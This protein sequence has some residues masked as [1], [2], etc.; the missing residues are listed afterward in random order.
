MKEAVD[1]YFTAALEDTTVI[2]NHDCRTFAAFVLASIVYKFEQGQINA[3]KNKL[4]SICLEQM[5]D[6]NPLLRKWFIICLGNLWNNFESARHLGVRD[7]AYEKL[8]EKL[9][10]D[11]VPEVRAATVYALG[12]FISSTIDRVSQDN[13]ID[14]SI[15]INLLNEVGND[16]SPLVRMELVA[17]LQ[18]IV[19]LFEKQFVDVCLR[20][21]PQFQSDSHLVNNSNNNSSLSRLQANRYLSGLSVMKP[22]NSCGS[23]VTMSNPASLG[24]IQPQSFSSVYSKI[25]QG[26]VSLSKD[27][28][29]EVASMGLKVAE[30]I[31]NQAIELIQATEAIS[32]DCR[33]ATSSFSLPPSP[34][35]KTNYLSTS[36][37]PNKE[38]SLNHYMKYVYNKSSNSLQMNASDSAVS[39]LCQK[40]P[41]KLRV[42]LVKT[43]FIEW[44]IASFARPSKYLLNEKGTGNDKHSMDT[45]K[46]HERFKRNEEIRKDA[47][48]QRNQTKFKMEGMCPFGKTMH[49]PNIVK[50]HPY[51]QQIVAAYREKVVLNDWTASVSLT[52]S[53]TIQ[54]SSTTVTTITGEWKSPLVSEK[55]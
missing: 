9:L 52:F 22:V 23:I 54:S 11:P 40:T 38:H 10:R 29:P 46:R 31:R 33:S 20:E 8:H 51:E 47:S 45:L 2:F 4:V 44:E 1:S 48:E 41:H 49:R 17:A 42:Q 35:N 27:P 7:S 24:I 18:W 32:N 28:Y 5:D 21:D 19:K 36:E 43:N 26:I 50:L 55:C 16:M 39:S 14:R 34:N 12:T 25:W 15:A 37:S 53:P 13:D 6:R 3:Q 30:Y